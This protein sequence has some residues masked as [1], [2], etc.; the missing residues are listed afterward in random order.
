MPAETGFQLHNNSEFDHQR[1]GIQ[2]PTDMEPSNFSEM[3]EALTA[4][5]VSIGV[6]KRTIDRLGDTRLDRVSELLGKTLDQ[7]WRASRAFPRVPH[8]PEL[9]TWGQTPGA[10]GMPRG[11]PQ[12]GVRND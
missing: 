9:L 1:N 3:I 10:V 11:T 5:G 4:V 12:D 8:V 6:A 2:L 7:Y